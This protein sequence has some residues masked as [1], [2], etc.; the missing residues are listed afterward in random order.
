MLS[1]SFLRLFTEMR[2]ECENSSVLCGA[3]G[4]IL[5]FATKRIDLE[6]DECKKC[7]WDKNIATRG[8]R[9]CA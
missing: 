8:L 4:D 9:G 2:D 6:W 7:A 3:N 5:L 1:S